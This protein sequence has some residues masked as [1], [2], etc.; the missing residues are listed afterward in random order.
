MSGQMTGIGPVWIKVD[1]TENEETVDSVELRV[2][3]S[4]TTVGFTD[5]H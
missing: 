3:Y 1:V 2:L 5:F 4:Y